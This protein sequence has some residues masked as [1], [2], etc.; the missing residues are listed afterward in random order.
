MI[1]KHLVA[2]GAVI[3]LCAWS[4]TAAPRI[5]IW[6]PVSGTSESRVSIDTN[7]VVTVA[8]TLTQSGATVQL[9]TAEQLADKT[10]FSA[11]QYDALFFLGN[12]FPRSVIPTAE[13][14]SN[15]GG[16]LVSLGAE[17][18]FL[19]AMEQGPEGFWKLSPASPPYAWQTEELLDFIGLKYLF[20]PTKHSQG[21]RHHPTRLLK[22]FAPNL[23]DLNGRIESRWVIPVGKAEYIP[24]IKSTRSDGLEVP[25]PLYI[26]KN[27]N[28]TSIICT[29]PIMVFNTLPQFWGQSTTTLTRIAALA[30]ALRSGSVSI[31]PGDRTQ[32]DINAKPELRMPLDRPAFGSVNPEDAE[33]LA[34]WG[35]FN[36]SCM[37]LGMTLASGRTQ[38]VA[39]A[40]S[41][42]AVPQA[43]AAGAAVLFTLPKASAQQNEPVFLRI[44]GAFSETGAGLCVSMGNT[45]LWNES[46]IYIDTKTAS[47]HSSSLSGVPSEFTR[48]IFIPRQAL[49]ASSSIVIANSGT[50]TVT[51]DAIQLEVQKKRRDRCI[52]LGSGL[53]GTNRYPTDES[54]KWG[55]IRMS[56]RTQRIGKPNDPDRFAKMDKLFNEVSSKTD[57]VQPILEGTP[58]WAPISKERLDDAIKG[59]RPTTVPPDPTLYAE[60]VEAVVKRY[61]DK[62]ATYEIWNEADITQFYRG[63]AQEY[64]NLFNTIVPIIRK[65]DPT[66]KIMPCGM[67]G[68]HE[69]FIDELLRSGVIGSCDLLAFHPY[70]GKSAAWDIPYGLIEGSLM[71]KGCNIEIFCNESGFPSSNREWFQRPPDLTEETQCEALDIAMARILSM[72]VAKLSVF[73]AGCDDGGFGLFKG[74]GEAKPA[75]AVFADYAKLGG[76]GA[77]RLDISLSDERGIPLVGVYAA[78][79]EDGQGKATVVINP[80]QCDE[81]IS[82]KE[83]SLPLQPHANWIGFFGKVAYENGT[84]TITP[85]EKKSAG[86]YKE[87]TINP[88]RTPLLD[89]AVSGDSAEW[90]LLLK[91]QDKT[92]LLAI[93][94]RGSGSV[95]L[96]LEDV[97]AGRNLAEQEIEISFRIHRGPARIERVTLLPDPKQGDKPGLPICVRIPAQSVAHRPVKATGKCHGKAFEIPVETQQDCLKARFTLTGRTVLTFE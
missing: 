37:E 17:V 65:L 46:F 69:A 84:A 40:S 43:L 94:K 72:G 78:A 8:N 1:K 14:F 56:F 2:L 76:T 11:D 33:P 45:L 70:A 27:G 53:D 31:L 96:N 60:I 23:P 4:A 26:V 52:G 64:V 3:A 62:I 39:S 93:P 61:G 21:V 89:V 35:L 67:A 10:L 32:L 74:T 49:S 51:F 66:A 13:Q 6:N 71:S 81:L 34:R 57:F 12:G 77:K 90:E 68:F 30:S 24:L 80:S 36:G 91:L 42:T 7:L 85:D 20:E 55:G 73:H 79:S 28:R 86:F 54:K 63:T 92:S 95:T 87:F 15:N 88:K 9:L 82:A 18:P 16:I 44:R 48:I 59:N 50:Q 22:T 58:D 83:Q 29:S 38:T 19:I 97:L 41:S 75:Y 5:A 25:G 47:N